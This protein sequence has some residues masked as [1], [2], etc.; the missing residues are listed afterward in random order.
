MP[1]RAPQ[2]RP[3]RLR[4]L[5]GLVLFVGTSYSAPRLGKQDASAVP[6]QQA[7]LYL[8]LAALGFGKGCSPALIYIVARIVALVL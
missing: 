2:A 5:C 8:E 4:L 3:L 7:G 1:L 6:E